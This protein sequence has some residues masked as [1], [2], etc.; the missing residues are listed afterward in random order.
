MH[1]AGKY[2]IART[3]K[4]G[5]LNKR[6]K[7]TSQCHHRNKFILKNF[8]EQRDIKFDP[9]LLL[10]ISQSITVSRDQSFDVFYYVVTVCFT[11]EK[12]EPKK[13]GNAEIRIAYTC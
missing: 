10:L 9:L 12:C 8:K 11:R 6:T 1:L 2:I 7:F 3:G 5:L 4:F 13:C